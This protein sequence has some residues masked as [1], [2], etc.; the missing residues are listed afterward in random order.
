MTVRVVLADD[1]PLVR[2]GLRVLIADTPDLE[3]VGEAANG[4]E[5]VRLARE[6]RPDVIVMDIRMPGMNGIE[7]TSLVTSGPGAARVLILTT[8]DE[9]D[10]V[11]GALRAGAS[12]FA[13]KDMALDDILAAIRVVAAG[14]ALIAPGIT[15]RLIADF[16]GR[17]EPSP[18]RAPRPVEGITEREREVLT[19]VGLGRSNSEIADELYITVATTKSHVAR[20]FTKLGARD[21]VQLVI[22][23]YE[24]GLVSA[25]R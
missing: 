17:P 8:F 16:V 2:S 11:Y 6:V 24:S 1:Q 25:P 23:A 5:A 21:R 15:R 13:V 9:D 18:A 12:G 19:L 10:H 14:D 20:L 7:A 3:V 4:E 22:I